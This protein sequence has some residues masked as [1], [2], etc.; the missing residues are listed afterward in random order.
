MHMYNLSYA[1]ADEAKYKLQVFLYSEQ[2]LLAQ[3]KKRDPYRI[4]FVP[5][6]RCYDANTKICISRKS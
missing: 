6:N 5:N 1:A 4:P 3:E 2:E